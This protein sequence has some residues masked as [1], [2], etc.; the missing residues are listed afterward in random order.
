MEYD[1]I[2]ALPPNENEDDYDPRSIDEIISS[3]ASASAKRAAEAGGVLL[4]M[5]MIVTPEQYAR[6]FDGYGKGKH[7]AFAGAGLIDESGY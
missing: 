5:D 6:F 3:S 7:S 2:L 1:E 4:D